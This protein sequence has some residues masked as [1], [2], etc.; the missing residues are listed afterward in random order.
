[1]TEVAA[2]EFRL[3]Q[4]VALVG[5]GVIG[6]GWAARLLLNGI[7]VSV[8]DPG[9]DAERRLLEVVDHARAAFDRLTFAPLPPEGR[10]SFADSIEAAVSGAEFVQES[11]PERLELKQ[12]LL[13][14]ISRSVAPDV[15]I[16]SSTSGLRPTDMAKAMDSPERLLVGHPFNPVYLIPLVELCGGTLTSS[17]VIERAGSLYRGI[18]MHPVTVR[19]EVDG[20]LADRLLE[21]LW[22][23]ALWL[24]NDDV[25]TVSEL[26][27]AIRYGA[28]LRWAF[29]GTF[30]T[31]RI[32]GGEQGMHHFLE[33][34]GPALA[35]PWTKLS[36]VPELTPELIDKI[37]AQSDAQAAGQSVSALEQWRDESLVSLLHGLR[38]QDSGAGATLAQWERRL[39]SIAPSGMASDA[40]G[41][42]IAAPLVLVDREVPP[43]WIDYNG[44]MTESRYLEL[45]SEAV[46]A[47]LRWIGVT[48][49]YLESGRSYFT[50]E[51]HL[52]H[53]GQLFAGERV[54]VS[55][56]M[57]AY[58][59]KRI[60]LFH[61]I[62][63]HGEQEPVA[64]AEQMQLHVD[65]TAGRASPAGAEVLAR[66]RALCDA[67]ATL[68]VPDAVGR[69]IVIP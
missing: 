65:S 62:A 39:M 46:D 36:D 16:A 54:T 38:S 14:Q 31:Y 10:L 41:E 24:V 30:L 51:T 3:P 25:A 6:G 20:F 21:A 34:F 22:R 56:Q 15:P 55:T 17:S 49:D 8:Y 47:L 37:V 4:A 53:L 66:V 50:V 35:L 9:P 61:S 63:R 43:S 44:H 28:G 1:M 52:R 40:A 12:E 18:G 57:L 58:D 13:A 48:G 23:E 68:T 27:D 33:Q 32:A 67:H 69:R 42:Q 19:T 5:G 29:M 7:D 26:D 45:F 59:E 60:H 2:S 64:T 11:T